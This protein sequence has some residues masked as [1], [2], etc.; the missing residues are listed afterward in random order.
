MR[1]T[2]GCHLFISETLSDSGFH[3]YFQHFGFTFAESLS[4]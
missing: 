3:K 2:E 1:F 4:E